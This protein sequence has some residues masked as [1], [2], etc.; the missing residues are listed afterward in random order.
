V[1]LEYWVDRSGIERQELAVPALATL[2]LTAGRPSGSRAAGGIETAATSAH[3]SRFAAQQAPAT[4]AG[5]QWQS[6]LGSSVL[7]DPTL[8]LG[9]MGTAA[10]GGGYSREEG[11]GGAQAQA[12]STAATAGAPVAGGPRV[13]H[14]GQPALLRPLSVQLAQVGGGQ[15]CGGRPQAGWLAAW[16]AGR[17]SGVQSGS[18]SGCCAFGSLHCE[19][20]VAPVCAGS[21]T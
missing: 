11:D 18:Y 16:L 14:T 20:L 19:V 21:V 5:R 6:V 17:L 2:A 9:S 1:Y 7:S 3:D 8:S 15:G 13:G 12:P 4:A 10:G